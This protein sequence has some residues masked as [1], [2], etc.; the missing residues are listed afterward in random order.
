[1]LILSRSSPALNQFTLSFSKFIQL[2]SAYIEA[3]VKK[4]FESDPFVVGIPMQE[5]RLLGAFYVQKERHAR[6]MDEHGILRRDEIDLQMGI[7]IT[8]QKYETESLFTQSPRQNEYCRYNKKTQEIE[9]YDF[10]SQQKTRSFPF[11][12]KANQTIDIDQE[13]NIHLQSIF[14]PNYLLINVRDWDL[15]QPVKTASEATHF[16]ALNLETG[17]YRKITTLLDERRVSIEATKK[18]RLAALEDQRKELLSKI[19]ADAQHPDRFNLFKID[20]EIAR[21][22]KDF[23][24]SIGFE[25]YSLASYPSDLAKPADEVIYFFTDYDLDEK[26]KNIS[27]ST[28]HTLIFGYNLTTGKT[29]PLAQF[30]IHV[31]HVEL[32]KDLKISSLHSHVN[33][34][35]KAFKIDKL[36]NP[37]LK[38]SLSVDERYYVTPMAYDENHV[39]LLDARFSDKKVPVLRSLVRNSEIP[40]LTEEEEAALKSDVKDAFV[41]PLSKELF[42]Y[43][44]YYERP[45]L[46]FK[47]P[48]GKTVNFSEEDVHNKIKMAQLLKSAN[49][50]RKKIG[51]NPDTI[52]AGE[53]NSERFTREIVISTDP[54]TDALKLTTVLSS[55]T[56]S[57]LS[58]LTKSKFSETQSFIVKARDG[59]EL[60]AYLTLPRNLEKH[61]NLAT[62]L[63]IH[64]GPMARD[65][66]TPD[67][68]IQFWASRGCAVVQI[69]FRGSKGFG[70]DFQK[71]AW[72]DWHGKPTDDLIDGLDHLI[73]QG[74]VDKGRII[75]AGTSY[76]A[77]ATAS[78]LTRYPDYFQCGIAVNGLYDLVEHFKI[79]MNGRSIHHPNHVAMQFG[80]DLRLKDQYAEEEAKLKFQSPINYVPNITK[81]LLV[82]TGSKDDNCLPEESAH[83]VAKAKEWGKSV[84]HVE[85]KSEG[86][87]FSLSNLP[88]QMGI[89]ENFVAHYVPGIY[90]EP[91]DRDMKQNPAI[92]MK[93]TSRY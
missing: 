4:D 80:A 88:H 36:G 14:N 31:T 21:I 75:A 44:T 93:T 11:P 8:S 56:T 38:F 86:H 79:T 68:E 6:L 92:K 42:G 23:G 69:N 53:F 45:V 2:A 47:T 7:F 73:Q 35:F 61:E 13:S 20:D 65:K 87:S 26:T 19:E 28:P 24:R 30:N 55:Q 29:R 83:F 78:L 32:S 48:K 76:G 70:K 16:W 63:L 85:F 34:E 17:E 51:A 12:L 82:M 10:P 25:Y 15:K 67:P 50:L 57:S 54:K 52:F 46:H 39:L 64:G 43:E 3:R 62:V 89:Q 72:G 77:F 59:L 81:P 66:L 41:V 91:M 18:E 22:K 40:L 1:M 9:V 71:A 84:T 90:A 74:I 27:S 58:R 37:E 33:R 49:H 5:Y 60:Q